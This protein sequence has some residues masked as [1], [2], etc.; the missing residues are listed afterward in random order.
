MKT[1]LKPWKKI[2]TNHSTDLKLFHARWDEME[3]PRTGQIMKRLILD[4]QDWVNIVPI[5]DEGKIVIVNQYRFGVDKFTA[6]IPGG[7][8]DKGENS[9]TAAI[10][11]LQEETGYTGGEW[12]YLGSVEPNPAFHTNLCHHWLA[13]GVEKTL[14]PALD[15]GEDIE[16]VTPTIKEL[17]KMISEGKLKHVLALSALSR[18][19]EIWGELSDDFIKK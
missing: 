19:A 4:T 1:S 16:V 18:V 7:L 11:E 3:N 17:K 15:P 8:I 12:F 9:K 5:T 13:R 6:E 14:K 10:R 2:R